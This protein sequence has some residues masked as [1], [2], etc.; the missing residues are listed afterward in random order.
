MSLLDPAAWVYPGELNAMKKCAHSNWGLATP[1]GEG[2]VRFI[3]LL[4]LFD[5]MQGRVDGRKAGGV[6]V[7]RRAK[8]DEELRSL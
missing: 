2:D 4:S 7:S 6:G 5:H 8:R 3:T 1:P